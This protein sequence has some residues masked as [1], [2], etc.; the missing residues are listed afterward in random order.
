MAFLSTFC[1]SHDIIS[2]SYSAHYS[3][4]HI[5]YYAS[6]AM[7]SFSPFQRLMGQPIATFLA[8]EMATAPGSAAGRQ[9]LEKKPERWLLFIP[10]GPLTYQLYDLWAGWGKQG[11]VCVDLSKSFL[12][13]SFYRKLFK[14]IILTFG[15]MGIAEAFYIF[16]GNIAVTSNRGQVPHPG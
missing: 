1:F 4:I 9:R 2:L 5:A 3:H 6:E 10:I 7:A 11:Q 8:G 12:V 15:K 16:A 13:A 14:F